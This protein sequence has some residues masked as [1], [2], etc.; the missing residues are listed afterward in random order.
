MHS[1]DHAPMCKIIPAVNHAYQQSRSFVAETNLRPYTD[2]L[3]WAHSLLIGLL[4]A[5]FFPLSMD[6]I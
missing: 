4:L 5:V 2:I 1:C 6:T 3:Y